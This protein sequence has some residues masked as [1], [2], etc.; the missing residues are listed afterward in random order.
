MNSSI[1]I[2]RYI[3]PS[4]LFLAAYGMS[5]SLTIWAIKSDSY[6][7][8]IA[9]VCVIASIIG[10]NLAHRWVMQGVTLDTIDKALKHH[11]R[12]VYIILFGMG[13]ISTSLASLILL[14]GVKVTDLAIF[15]TNLPLPHWI[16]TIILL[17]IAEYL[18]LFVLGLGCFALGL[19]VFFVGFGRGMSQP[20][21]L[22][23]ATVIG[24]ILPLAI[25]SHYLLPVTGMLG[26]PFVVEGVVLQTT[27]HTCAPASIATLARW[28]GLDPSLSERDVV[29]LTHTSRLG[30]TALA[31]IRAMRQLGL[32]PK[33]QRQLTIADLITTNQ[34][35]VLSVNEDVDGVIFL[36][37]VVL[38]SINPESQ[39]VTV[40]NPLYGRQVKTFDHIN[41]YWT[42]DAVFVTNPKAQKL[43]NPNS[44]GDIPK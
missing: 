33:Y 7:V 34:P 12:L 14:Q 9:L 26:E 11:Q 38:L 5:I 42:G 30:T 13:A 3:K 24:M 37:A 39:T 40:G 44:V 22:L 43:H 29:Q 17:Y 23:M 31:E 28:V 4:H 16:P 10:A 20:L 36:H 41:G 18:N 19:V 15:A 32:A 27:S 35:A 25:F 2:V 1:N 6:T 21:P 8:F